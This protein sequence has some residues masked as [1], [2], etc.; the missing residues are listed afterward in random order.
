MNNATN[1][2]SSA[3]ASLAIALLVKPD[4]DYEDSKSTYCCNASIHAAVQLSG[5]EY[6]DAKW[7]PEAAAVRARISEYIGGRDVAETYVQ[8][9]LGQDGADEHVVYAFRV[10]MMTEIAAEFEAKELLQRQIEVLQQVKEL[11]ATNPK[12]SNYVCDN[13]QSGVLGYTPPR[14]LGLRDT[15]EADAICADINTY[16]GGKFSLDV[17]M[18]MDEQ[19]EA[20]EDAR[21]EM[22]DALIARYTS[23]LEAA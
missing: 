19:H 3:I 14:G 12:R 20:V 10:K 9:D 6:A 13:I 4:N 23:K 1:L 5:L 8:E 18:G 21:I 7:T 17:W 15:P 2:K 16:I 11:R 22:I